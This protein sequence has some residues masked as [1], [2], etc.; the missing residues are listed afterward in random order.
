MAAFEVFYR[1]TYPSLVSEYVINGK[2]RVVHR[3]FPLPQHKYARLAA[4]YANA[5][6]ELGLYDVAFNRSF[7]T[8]SREQ[9]GSTKLLL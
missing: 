7:E 6:D 5:A 4:R 2:V 9:T 3:D 1:D 8:Q